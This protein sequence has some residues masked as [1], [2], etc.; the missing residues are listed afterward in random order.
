MSALRDQQG[1]LKRRRAAGART[2]VFMEA[3]VMRRRRIGVS[4]VSVGIGLFA[5]HCGENANRGGVER[6]ENVGTQAEALSAPRGNAGDL[7]AD[8]EVGRRDFT[9]LAPREIV[10]D[11]VSS[12]GGVVVDRSVSPG[13]AYIWDSGNSRILGVDLA[14][15]YATA[16][17]SRCQPQIIIGQPSGSDRGAC[18]LDS[19][20]QQYP[21]RPPASASTL[22]GVSE[23]TQTVLE[24]KSFA[25]M[26]VD[27]SANLWVPDA[28]NHRV[29][30]YRTPFTTDVVADDVWGQPNFTANGCNGAT[31]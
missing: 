25:N 16:A 22:C 2:S 27:G 19:S 1:T 26:F 13:R 6:A 11:K 21:L 24:D 23:V 30:M 28:L 15:C 31:D 7:I 18:N 4:I 8:V 12:P 14:Q 17:G 10:P 5:L 9:E 20:A 29:L 3:V